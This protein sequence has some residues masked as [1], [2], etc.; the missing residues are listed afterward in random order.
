MSSLQRFE[1]IKAWKKARELS[2]IIY[3]FTVE[4]NFKKD[5]V[6]RDQIRRSCVS[7]MSNIAEGFDRGGNREFIHFLYIAK[8][9]TAELE[10]QL[11][12][13]LDNGYIHW[14][15]FDKAM[16]LT[17]SIKSLIAGF[18]RY[19]KKSDIKGLKYKQFET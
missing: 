13:A 4:G 17:S 9:S 18:I 10:S 5:F 3:Q 2:G 7:I 11:Y 19:L 1:D 16:E 15:Q 14:K 12:I 6:L 8:G